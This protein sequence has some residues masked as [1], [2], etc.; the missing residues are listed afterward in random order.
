MYISIRP[1]RRLIYYLFVDYPSMNINW[2]APTIDIFGLWTT[3]QTIFSGLISCTNSY[4]PRM[5]QCIWNA[6]VPNP[7]QSNHMQI[8]KHEYIHIKLN[9]TNVLC[10]YH[11][12]IKISSLGLMFKH[13]QF[14]S[15]YLTKH[16]FSQKYILVSLFLGTVKP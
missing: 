10:N 14:D 8:Y 1:L 12:N 3:L 6:C 11:F 7:I 2:A 9:H 5:F 13:K 4:G 15:N 16:I